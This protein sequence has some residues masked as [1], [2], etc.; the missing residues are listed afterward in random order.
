MTVEVVRVEAQPTL[1]VRA[2]IAP[3]EIATHGQ[4][5]LDTVHAL[6]RRVEATPG[7]NVMRYRPHGDR[8]DFEVG[9]VDPGGVAPEGKVVR[10]ALPG[11][12]VARTLHVGPY[13]DLGA[14]HAV[15]DAWCAEHG[16]RLSGVRWE[17]YGHWRDDAPP[18]VE[19]IALLER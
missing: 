7:R 18:E 3:D 5:M 16:H 9:V 4:R 12:R 1:V 14:T 17:I 15:L 2:R 8:L 10:S 19:V 6:V 13:E 11:G